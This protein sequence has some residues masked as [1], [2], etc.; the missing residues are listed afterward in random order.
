MNQNWPKLSPF[1]VI[2]ARPGV[3]KPIKTNGFSTFL[4]SLFLVFLT[5]FGLL[6]GPSWRS[7]GS[8]W[9]LLG[10]LRRPK[11]S[12]WG[13]PGGPWGA[14]GTLETCLG[15]LLGPSWGQCL[16]RQAPMAPAWPVLEPPGT[17]SAPLGGHSRAPGGP[18]GPT[19]TLKWAL[20]CI[21][22]T[23]FFMH[24]LCDQIEEIRATGAKS[25]D[26]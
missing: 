22:W 15:C 12:F 8:L 18:K 17:N 23:I 7:L 10:P 1:G 11:G 25:I 14:L 3:K 26:R 16:F 21:L 20:H 19:C 9:P 6:L 2:L 4:P 24:F 5:T 13:P